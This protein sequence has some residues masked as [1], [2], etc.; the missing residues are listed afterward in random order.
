MILQDLEKEET[1]LHPEAPYKKQLS[2][3][4]ISGFC[5]YSTGAYR[6]VEDPLMLYRGKHCV[7]VFYKHIKEE[8]KRLYH[9]FP[10]RPMKRLTQEEWREFKGA[11]KC[12]IC[13]NDFQEDNNYKVRDHCHHTGLY[14][15]PAP[16]KCNLRYKIPRYIPVV[17][18]NLSGYN[19][20]LFIRELGKKFD[21]GSA[22]GVIAENKEKCISFNVDVVRGLY[23]DMWGK[24]KEKK[25]QLRFINS[26]KFMVSSLDSL[27]R[28][29]AGVNGMMCK[30]RSR[31][32]PH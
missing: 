9:M 13:F 1:E 32:Y 23:K 17:F 12:H 28:N 11:T 10:E 26:I 29:L 30:C 7:E 27:A 24:T 2:R 25:I 14:Q 15:G 19:T 22:I 21:S 20:I 6:E 3:H 5:T 4:V 8:A 31:T 18:H 16:R